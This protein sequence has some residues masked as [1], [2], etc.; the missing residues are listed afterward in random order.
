MIQNLFSRQQQAQLTSHVA[1]SFCAQSRTLRLADFHRQHPKVSFKVF[2][3]ANVV[4]SNSNIANVESING[5]G[6]WQ[7]QQV[8]LLT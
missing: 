1:H 7:N 3:T 5:H 8:I 6:E 4:P 2:T